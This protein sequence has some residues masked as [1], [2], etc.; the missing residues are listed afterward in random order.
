M[1]AAAVRSRPHAMHGQPSVRMRR[2]RSARRLLPPTVITKHATA[3]SVAPS[4]SV[5]VCGSFSMESPAML[6]S[7]VLGISTDV[8]RRLAGAG[9]GAVVTKS[10]STEPWDGYPNPTVVGAR[11]DGG[12]LNAVGLSN[13]GAGAMAE[14]IAACTGEGGGGGGGGGAA[15]PI[16]APVVASLVGSAESDFERIIGAFEG[17]CGRGGIAAY[18]LNLSCPHV[19]RVGLEVGDDPDLVGRI[20]AAS[21]RSTDAPVIAKV[22]L[23]T[24]HFVRTAEAAAAAGASAVTAINTV[25]AMMIDVRARAPVLSNRV[26]GLS[27]APIR[28]VAVRCV[29]ELAAALDIPVIGCGGVSG[30][31]DA[32]EF[33]LAGACAVQVGSAVSGPGGAGVFGRINDGLAAYMEDGGFGRVSEMVGLAQRR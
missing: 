3:C 20:V 27:G 30:W 13:P 2:D 18:E 25:R 6:A 21:A 16:G 32:A 7:G 15:E 11:I 12:W 14:M 9:A 31:E 22:G 26:G 8:F 23:G 10:V 4:L 28:P 17:A 29:Y 24:T 19:A 1:P 5:D 33:I